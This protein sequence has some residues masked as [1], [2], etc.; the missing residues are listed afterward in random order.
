MRA[1]IAVDIPK[2]IKE[3]GKAKIITPAGTCI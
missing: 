1:F 2:K 3:L